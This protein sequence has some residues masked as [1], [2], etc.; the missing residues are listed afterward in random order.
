[1]PPLS[2][3]KQFYSPAPVLATAPFPRLQK[4]KGEHINDGKTRTEGERCGRSSYKER[5]KEKNA[6]KKKL[7]CRKKDKGG[8]GRGKPPPNTWR[9]EESQM[10]WWCSKRVSEE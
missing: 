6:S 1:M 10:T 4:E 2:E 9:P 5:G 3:G 8:E 7:R